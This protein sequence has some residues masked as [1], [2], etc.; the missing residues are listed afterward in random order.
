MK[1]PRHTWEGR[2]NERENVRI[3]KRMLALVPGKKTKHN[4]VNKSFCNLTL[5]REGQVGK[6]FPDG[7]DGKESTC[8]AGDPG[9]IP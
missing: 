7:S 2:R 3:L 5:L 1:N 8:N 4:T 6:G 9:S